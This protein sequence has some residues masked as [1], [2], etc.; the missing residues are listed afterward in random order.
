M[1]YRAAVPPVY[2]RRSGSAGGGFLVASLLLLVL[3]ACEREPPDE[4]VAEID[5][6]ETERAQLEERVNELEQRADAL[7]ELRDGVEAL[8]LPASIREELDE[9]PPATAR[10]S[11]MVVLDGV[12]SHAEALQGEL[13]GAR[14]QA[15]GLQ[16]QVD[17]MQAAAEESE[18]EWEARLSQE[19]G[20]VSQLESQVTELEGERDVLQGQVAD[21]EGRVDGLQSE[22][23]E[24]NVVAG[25][26][27]ELIDQGIIA[28]EG[29]ARV[30]LGLFWRRGEALVPA[31]EF[32]PAAFQQL[33]RREA[34]E[35]DLPRDDVRYHVISRQDLSY[36]DPAPGNDRIVEGGTLY[37]TDT[38][39]F[40]R[41]SR[42]LILMQEE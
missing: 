11:V 41:N 15:G 9:D 22:L 12:R 28:E 8:E 16:A 40:W 4:M 27:Q 37:V 3:G 35:I 32:D 10:D 36:L 7:D 38:D 17:S 19:E 34:H 13:Q 21:L 42:Y 23:H 33:D 1:K 6:L 5:A 20:R 26:R 14:G 18:E 2:E 39:A 29:G 31:R 30:V 24:V 25:T